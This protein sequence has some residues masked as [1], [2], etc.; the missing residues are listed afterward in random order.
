MKYNILWLKNNVRFGN[1]IVDDLK[2][3]TIIKINK[4]YERSEQNERYIYN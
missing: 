3:K 1:I 2:L 4:V